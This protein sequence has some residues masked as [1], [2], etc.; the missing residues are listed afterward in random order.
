MFNYYCLIAT[1]YLLFHW[2]T[3]VSFSNSKN[4]ITTRNLFLGYYA[5]NAFDNN[6][7]SIWV[8][9]G[10]SSPG[11]NWIAYEFSSPVKINSVRITGEADHQDRTPGMWYVEASCEKYFKTYSTQ[12]I[13]ENHDHQTD[14]RWN[15]PRQQRW[16]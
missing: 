16:R 14:K 10:V 3:T 9:N 4:N 1:S 8:S 11:L 6:P 2:P 13:I 12:W 5:S 15:R 7:D